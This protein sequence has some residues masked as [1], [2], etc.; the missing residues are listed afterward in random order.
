M[1]TLSVMSDSLQFHGLSPT[2]LWDYPGKNTKVSC[3]FLFQ[4][5]FLTQGLNPRHLQLLHWNS[6][7]LSH[8]PKPNHIIYTTLIFDTELCIRYLILLYLHCTLNNQISAKCD[9]GPSHEYYYSL[10]VKSQY[11]SLE[12]E[13]RRTTNYLRIF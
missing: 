7:S 9:C 2:S 4:G 12:F 5:I 11:I 6:L 13:L 8:L 1:L 3:H 10:P